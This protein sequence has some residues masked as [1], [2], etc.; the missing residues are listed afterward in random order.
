LVLLPDF[1]TFREV[2]ISMNALLNRGLMACLAAAI[3]SNSPMAWAQ[4]EGAAGG[5][6]EIAVH[7]ADYGAHQVRLL[8]ASETFSQ[9]IDINNAGAVIGLR[10]VA[11]ENQTIF[12]QR[13]FYWDEQTALEMPL[14]EGF[15]NVEAVALSDDGLVVGYA[16]RAIGNPDGS[17]RAVIWD[18]TEH[19]VYSIPSAA[20]DGVAQAQGISADG[21]TV[22]GITVGSE[23]PKVRPCVWR[24]KHDIGSE[25]SESKAEWECQPLPTGDE[26]NPYLMASRVCVSPDGSSIAGCCTTQRI[27]FGQVESSLFVWKRSETGEWKQE[28]ISDSQMYLRDMN[29]SGQMAGSI[30]EGGKRKPVLIEPNGTIREI[31]L[32][33]GDESGEAWA[34]TEN[35]VVYGFSDDPHGPEGGPQAFCWSAGQTV[36]IDLGDAPYSAI[37]ATNDAGWLAGLVDTPVEVQAGEP[38]EMTVGLMIAP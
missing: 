17:V 19:R 18:T 38:A 37:Y 36:K 21:K 35:G 25:E 4:S 9:V 2:T 12:F 34:I 22:V 28:L 1:T 30:S 14:L 7:E 23:P 11:N 16:S 8:T 32:L 6:V 15:T 27:D 29:S 26:Y 33:E 31:E 10:E 3:G 20:G 13:Y 24:R 5:K